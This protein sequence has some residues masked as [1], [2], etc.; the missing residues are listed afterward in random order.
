MDAVRVDGLAR[1]EAGLDHPTDLRIEQRDGGA[2]DL[3][4][5]RNAPVGGRTY[6][7]SDGVVWAVHGG[8]RDAMDAWAAGCDQEGGPDDGG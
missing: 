8:L 5:G 6:V 1:A 4:V 2:I 3:L 7:A